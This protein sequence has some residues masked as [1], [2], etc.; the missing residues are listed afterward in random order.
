MK[1]QVKA[2]YFG[3]HEFLDVF[4]GV[5][6]LPGEYEIELNSTIQPVQNRPRKTPQVMRPAVEATLRSLE[7]SGMIAC[8]SRHSN[9][10]DQ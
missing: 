8:M 2:L 4:S 9:Q 7:K 1:K 10:V 6:C 5:G 3:I